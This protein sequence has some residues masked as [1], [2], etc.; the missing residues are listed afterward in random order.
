MV[1]S[2]RNVALTAPY[3]HDGRLATLE[4]VVDHY[5]DGLQPSAGLDV[6]LARHRARGG[7]GLRAD[8]R[9]DLVAFLRTLTDEELEKR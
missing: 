3:M 7:L 6:N 5:S 1:P 8:E 9:A 4:A 2:L